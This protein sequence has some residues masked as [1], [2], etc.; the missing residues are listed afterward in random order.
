VSVVLAVSL[1][2]PAAASAHLRAG[3]LST[4]F[5]A[6]VGGL[7]PA[8]PGVGARVL[9]GDQRLEL[10]VAPGRVVVVLGLLGEPFLR[11]SATGVEAN[12][13]SPTA[14][15]TR[16]VKAGDTVVSRQPS[17]RRVGRGHAFAWHEGRLRPMA[18]VRDPSTRPRAV[19]TWS[20]PLLVDGRSASLVGSE[21]YAAAPPVWPWLLAGT[22]LIALAILGARVLSAHTGRLV[23]SVLLPLSVAGCLAAWLGSFLADRVTIL[24]VLFAVGFAG[25]T[26]LLLFVAAAAASGEA[27]LGAMA[28]IGG[29]TATFALPQVVVFSHGFVLSALPALAARLAV[30]TALVGGIVVATLCLPAV[31]ALLEIKPGRLENRPETK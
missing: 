17:W 29:F 10:R 9:G 31:I 6:R 5:E 21:W 12:L 13:A 19:A 24:M 18:A 20:I 8:V 26:A 23:A 30:A 27:R 22:L 28:L 11:F 7:R 1:A 4:D 16:V 2:A 3:T 14:S 15:S 25:A